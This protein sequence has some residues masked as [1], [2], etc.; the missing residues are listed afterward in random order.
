MKVRDI[1]TKS[2]LMVKAD[3][4]VNAIAKLMGEHNISGVPVVDDQ[5][6]VLGIVTEQ[7]LIVRNTRLEMAHFIQVLDLGRIPLEWPSHARERMRH[8][9]GTLA[10]DV[11][12]SK[13]TTV[14]PD[15]EIE[16]LA[17]LMVKH[18]VN[19]VPV[20]ENEQLIGIVSRADLIDMMAAELG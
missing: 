19:P 9:L 7:D 4:S 13:V 12:T 6:H 14:G 5:N 15:V 10:T 18:G 8:M 2:V 20:I 11:M 3:T 17:E 1:M 16:E